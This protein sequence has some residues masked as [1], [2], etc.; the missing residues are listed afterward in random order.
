MF[1]TLQAILG[2][3]YVNDFNRFGRL[4]RVFVQAEPE[5]RQKPADI[6]S[7][8][9]RSQHDRTRWSR[10]RRCVTITP[11]SGTEIT[12]A[13]TCSARSRSAARRRRATRR[14]RR[15]RRSKRWP[16]EVLPPEMGYAYTGMSYQE[17]IAPSS[18]P[19]FVMAVVFVFLLLAALY[20]SWSLPFAVLLGTPGVVLGALLGVWARGLDNNVYVQIGLVT[21]IGLAAKNSILIV[22]FAKAAAREGRG[23]GRGGHRGGPPALPADPDDRVRVHHGL[24]PAD[25]RLRAPARPRAR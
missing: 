7:F 1:S 3:A 23:R 15:W 22:E 24:R 4:Y 9:V 21:L 19:T 17:K 10:C 20:E 25:A 6:G 2:G 16:A 8:Y 13:S 5:Y 11:V 18:A 14:A 12:T